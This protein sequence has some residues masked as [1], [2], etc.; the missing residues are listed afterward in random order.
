MVLRLKTRY[1]RD[2]VRIFGLLWLPRRHWRQL[3]F[4]FLGLILGK[5]RVL[6]FGG[7]DGCMRESEKRVEGIRYFWE[8]K[9]VPDLGKKK[10][11]S[12]SLGGLMLVSNWLAGG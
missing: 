10:F 2:C 6:I 1:F 5:E 3:S 11:T 9:R 7:K 8:K 12:S 4:G